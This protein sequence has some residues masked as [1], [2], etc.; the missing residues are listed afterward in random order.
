[1]SKRR[2]SALITLVFI[3]GVMPQ[4][5]AVTAKAGGSCTK[6]KATSIVGGKKYTCIKSGK[7]LVWDK[8]VAINPVLT[9]DQVAKSSRA[10]AVR[11]AFDEI[12]NIAKTIVVKSTDIKTV[13]SPEITS[14][15]KTNIENRYSF[16]ASFFDNELSAKSPVTLVI[17]TN[18]EVEWV[19][20]QLALLSGKPFEQ[21]LANFSAPSKAATCGP[22]Y[23]AGSNG[24]TK[25]GR[26]LNNYNLFGKSCATQLPSDENFQTTI[27]HE[28][29]HNVQNAIS[30]NFDENHNAINRNMPCWFTEGQAVFYG[31][32][33]GYRND[34][35]GYLKVREWNMKNGKYRNAQDR[36]DVSR[37]LRKLDQ[38][39]DGFSCGNDGGYSIGSLAVE[40]M[41]LMKG[42]AGILAFMKELKNQRDWQ[43]AFEVIYGIDGDEW[44][45]SIGKEIAKEYADAGLSILPP[46]S[47]VISCPN[48]SNSDQAGIS[49]NRANALLGMTESQADNCAKSLNWGF[50][51]G[52]RDKEFYPMTMDYRLDRVTIK[53]MVG[54][55]TRVDVG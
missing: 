3:F 52:Q 20:N 50:R 9:A 19:G 15:S 22:Y 40:K 30:F 21:W 54:L 5:N 29:V 34:F 4:V 45:A 24:L 31:S 14:S 26:I 32:T 43:E 1:M 51:I 35:A 46:V 8:G 36:K 28:W 37:S 53:L 38:S 10:T 48:P 7:K 6:L 49:R 17:G 39:Y 25:D 55:V 44:V 33:L 42:H 11:K 18:A 13:T 41:I 12:A 16:V 27:E 2:Y 47:E 23:S